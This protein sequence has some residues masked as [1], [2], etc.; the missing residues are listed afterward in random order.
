MLAK[1]SFRLIVLFHLITWT[2]LVSHAQCDYGGWVPYSA[3]WITVSDDF[4]PSDSAVLAFIN[5]P[6]AS[7]GRDTI[8]NVGCQLGDLIEVEAPPF[9]PP[10]GLDVRWMPFRPLAGN[11]TFGGYPSDV[12]GVPDNPLLQDTFK[13][14]VSY[15]GTDAD[16]SNFTLKW[17]DPPFLLARCDSLFLVPL[18]AGLVGLDS[19]PIP[20]KIDMVRRNRIDLFRPV[21]YYGAG[22][23]FV[24][25]KY[26]MRFPDHTLDVGEQSNGIPSAYSLQQNYPNPFNPETRISFVVPRAGQVSLVVYDV[27]GRQV[28]TLIQ[29]NKQP[30][31]YSK[32]WDAIGVPSGVY[33]CRLVAGEFVSTKKM[34]LMR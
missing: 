34:I 29:E 3:V 24:V 16:S 31:V 13:L 22:I 9:P 8:H 27:L 15:S 12:R 4:S 1:N 32:T 5:V 28:E 30:G 25:F 26:G 6:G 19:N 7:Y 23:K 17:P 21:Q 14:W 2:S 18:T 11:P 20:Q 33:Y 10:M